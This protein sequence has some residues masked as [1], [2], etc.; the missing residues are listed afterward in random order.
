MTE[1]I[2]LLFALMRADDEL[3]SMMDQ[4]SLSNVR[5]EVAASSSECVGAAAFL[6]FRVTPQNIHNLLDKNKQT[7]KKQIEVLNIAFPIKDES[8]F[9]TE[10]N[11]LTCFHSCSCC[12]GDG[13]GTEDRESRKGT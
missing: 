7:N 13:R 1:L 12:G 3:Q 5:A 6:G 4:Q 11:L 8:L 10:S 2:S 9:S